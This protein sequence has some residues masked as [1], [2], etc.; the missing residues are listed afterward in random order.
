MG[1]GTVWLGTRVNKLRQQVCGQARGCVTSYV[2]PSLHCKTVAKVGGG[3]EGPDV[4]T[5]GTLEPR[6][7][8]NC[9]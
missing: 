6:S 2:D 9:H 4:V 1:G 5:V 8:S 3:A 7:R